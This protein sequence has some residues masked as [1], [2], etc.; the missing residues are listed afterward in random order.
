[1]KILG[2][3][4]TAVLSLGLVVAAWGHRVPFA[5]SEAFG[6]VTGAWCVWLA[7]REHLWNWPIGIASNI[8]YVALFWHT[9]LYA[10]MG[11]QAIYIILG[12]LG[13]YWWLH[14]GHKRGRLSVANTPSSTALVLLGLVIVGTYGMTLYLHNTHDSAPFWDALTTALSLAAQYLIT[15]K[16]LENWYV[17][18]ATEM[19]YVGLYFYKHLF[20]T[21]GLYG[22]FIALCLMGLREWR[23]SQAESA[24]LITLPQTE[25]AHG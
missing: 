24:K 19:I 12:A 21:A 4:I 8:F 17:W 20:L 14:G 23:R 9:R 5:P 6:F 15:K 3:S 1:M 10:D 16:M 11:L 18:I 22:L 7:V 2:Y 25:V 13:W